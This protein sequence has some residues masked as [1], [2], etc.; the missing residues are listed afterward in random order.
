MGETEEVVVGEGEG[1]A[2][3]FS[4]MSLTT[5]GWRWEAEQRCRL[6]EVRAFTRLLG[7]AMVDGFVG[8]RCSFR[9]R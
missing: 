1:N 7:F 8:E 9:N 3:L 5:R 6:W 4:F 2:A